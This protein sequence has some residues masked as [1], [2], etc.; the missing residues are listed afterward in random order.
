MKS[1]D[2]IIIDK[3][4]QKTPEKFLNVRV[5]SMVDHSDSKTVKTQKSERSGKSEKRRKNK[6]ED[7]DGTYYSH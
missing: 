3:P 2:K 6:D 5:D 4:S 1:P 7:N